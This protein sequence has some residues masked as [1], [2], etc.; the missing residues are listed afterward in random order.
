[1][2]LKLKLSLL[3]AFLIFPPV[4]PQENPKRHRNSSLG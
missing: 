4:S 1:M 3:L 2:K